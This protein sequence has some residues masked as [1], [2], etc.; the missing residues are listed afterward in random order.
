MGA[1]AVQTNMAVLGAEQISTSKITS[2]Y[3]DK[4][5]IAVNTASILT[6][7]VIPSIERDET[8]YY[9]AYIIAAGMLCLSAILFI[10]G[11]KYY[12]RIQPCD[13]VVIHCIP[14]VINAYQSWRQYKKM[15]HLTDKQNVNVS[16]SLSPST[17][18]DFAKE[19]NNG[20]FNDRVVEDVKLIRNAFIVFGFF[21]PFWLV[22][23]QV[24]FDFFIKIY[25]FFLFIDLF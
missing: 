25:F 12:I 18:L 19:I 3:F 24:T 17:F 8:Y 21:I 1:G 16:Q 9:I 13:S 10:L 22:D 2:R 14:V 6:R 5:I 20:K 7:M 11:W 4:Y 15:K 23:N